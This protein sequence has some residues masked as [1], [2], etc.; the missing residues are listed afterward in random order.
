MLL[1]QF[2]PV[3]TLQWRQYSMSQH[4]H[5][6]QLLSSILLGARGQGQ[7]HI[8]GKAGC[9]GLETPLLPFCFLNVD[10]L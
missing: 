6:T 8:Q 2:K 9:R 7:G 10:Q 3:L 4:L 1:P 5:T